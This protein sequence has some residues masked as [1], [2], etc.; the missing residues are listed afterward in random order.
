MKCLYELD[1]YGKEPDLY[2]RGKTKVNTILGVVF[3][4]LHVAIAFSYFLF[5]FIRMIKRKDVKFY[6]TYAFGTEI[7]EITITNEQYYAAF[8]MGG[9]IDETLYNIRAQYVSVFKN[10]DTWNNTYVELEFETCKLEKFG[11]K[12]REFFK[13][14]RLNTS[15]CL[16]NVNLTLKGYSYLKNFSYI[17]LQIRPCV[18]YTKD[19]RPCKDY[20]TILKFFSQNYIQFKIQDNL[21]TP[22]NYKSPVKAFK[23]DIQSPIF[24]QLYQ[25]IYSYIQIVRVETEE[26]ILGFSF[27]PKNKMEVFTKY[28]NSYVISAPGTANILKTGDPACDITLQLDANVLTQTRYYTTLLDVMGEVGGLMEFLFTFFNVILSFRVG[29]IYEK[30]LVNDLFAF[31]KS[32]KEVILKKIDVKKEIKDLESKD[33][34]KLN[35]HQ[36]D[37]KIYKENNKL[38]RNIKSMI[39]PKEIDINKDL[40]KKKKTDISDST[41]TNLDEKP[42]KDDIIEN[43]DK[44]CLLLRSKKRNIEK[45]CFLEGKRLI[46]ENLDIENLFIN[47]YLVGNNRSIFHQNKY[48]PISEK[49]R[50]YFTSIEDKINAI[51]TSSESGVIK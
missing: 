39:N 21:L 49:N 48:V 29:E 22:D 42:E 17:N 44:I 43:I 32:T 3:T 1:L 11:S 45:V 23:K 18:N 14:E 13:E 25:K 15:Y 28:Q 40:N 7:P 50:K 5:K 27:N 8:T 47:S 36:S 10:G 37:S 41:V 38:H 19:G 2:Y 30:S 12:Y 31:N 16:K 26:D 46:K 33:D 6:D 34:Q 9:Y 20:N 4:F 35:F 51:K 24:L